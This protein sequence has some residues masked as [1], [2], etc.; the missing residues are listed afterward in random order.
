MRARSGGDVGGDAAFAARGARRKREADNAETKKMTKTTNIMR[1]I[2]EGSKEDEHRSRHRRSTERRR[3]EEKYEK[4]K[5]GKEKKR[6]ANNGMQEKNKKNNDNGHTRERHRGREGIGRQNSG[7]GADR[8]GG[9]AVVCC[10]EDKERETERGKVKQT[11]MPEM[12]FI[13]MMR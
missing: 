3:R 10:A 5:K 12:A 11:L 4:K 7:R 2:G 1:S 13:I 6:R 8:E 9:E